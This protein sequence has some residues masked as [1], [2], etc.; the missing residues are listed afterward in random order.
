MV[1]RIEVVSKTPDSREKNEVRKLQSLG[2]PVDDVKLVEVYTIDA[3]LSERR[4]E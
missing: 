4:L 3:K 2:F 1:H